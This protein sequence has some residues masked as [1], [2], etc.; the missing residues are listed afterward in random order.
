HFL[1]SLPVTE[2]SR[3]YPRHGAKAGAPDDVPRIFLRGAWRI[4]GLLRGRKP[5]RPPGCAPRRQDPQ[6]SKARR[7]PRRAADEVRARHQLE[8]REGA[9]LVDP[10]IR[11]VAGGPTDRVKVFAFPLDSSP[12]E[13]PSRI[14]TM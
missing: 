10:S 8:N 1:A 12:Q 4:G 2:H 5:A 3:L 11:A 7:A 14:G 13:Q 9:R 6:R